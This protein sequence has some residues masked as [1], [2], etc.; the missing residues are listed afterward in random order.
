MFC[1]K[2]YLFSFDNCPQIFSIRFANRSFNGM[3]FA[4]SFDGGT[5]MSIDTIF[6]DEKLANGEQEF[7]KK[8]LRFFSRWMED[9]EP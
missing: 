4:Q 9:Q 8:R 3:L 7:V 2:E 1:S 6:P 5:I